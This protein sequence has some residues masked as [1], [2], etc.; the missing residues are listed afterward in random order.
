MRWIDATA[1]VFNC[2]AA[3]LPASIGAATPGW[4]SPYAGELHVVDD[5]AFNR[6]RVAIN[7]TRDSVLRVRQASHH[8]NVRLLDADAAA[9]QQPGAGPDAD[10]VALA[11]AQPELLLAHLSANRNYLIEFDELVRFWGDFCASERMAIAVS[12]YERVRARRA[13]QRRRPQQA[14][15]P[16]ASEQQRT[17]RTCSTAD[18]GV[19]IV[20]PT[21]RSPLLARRRSAHPVLIATS[22]SGL[23]RR[24]PLLLK[25]YPGSIGR[26]R[27]APGERLHRKHNASSLRYHCLAP[28]RTRCASS[29][30]RCILAR[31]ATGAYA[32][33]ACAH[34]RFEM[35]RVAGADRAA[36]RR[37]SAAITAAEAHRQRRRHRRQRR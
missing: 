9:A 24:R 11:S 31:R 2:D 30:S 37:A 26:Q 15:L 6:F 1:S 27:A 33:A 20:P 22:G 16:A 13:C 21:A 3:D 25:L 8:A 29:E 5:F 35:P 36:D 7:V 12:P 23:R 10:V 19:G 14:T 4:L 17:C 28:A 34:V 32:F 18:D